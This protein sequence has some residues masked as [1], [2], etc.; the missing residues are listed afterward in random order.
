M[1]LGV[2]SRQ[3]HITVEWFKQNHS[4]CQLKEH[5]SLHPRLWGIYGGDI[6]LFRFR[7][8]FCGSKDTRAPG[9]CCSA[10]VTLLWL[11]FFLFIE[12]IFY[13]F[14]ICTYG[15]LHAHEHTCVGIHVHGLIHTCGH[16]RLV[17]GIFLN[18]TSPWCPDSWPHC[19]DLSISLLTWAFQ[20]VC[21]QCCDYKQGINVSRKRNHYRH[22]LKF[23]PWYLNFNNTEV[24]K[25][26]HNLASVQGK[27]DTLVWPFKAN[28]DSGDNEK[29]TF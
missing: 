17:L 24:D 20:C 22:S 15:I 18:H 23:I 13:S 4:S 11:F 5:Q 29:K 27:W 26:L 16:L 3:L 25:V 19:F 9:I 28:F 7:E 6:L 8:N 10:E 14:H 1:D 21:P 12:L 2:F